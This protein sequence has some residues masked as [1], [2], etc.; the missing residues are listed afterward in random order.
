M[1]YCTQCAALV[2]WR[3]PAGDN[4][5]RHVCPDCGTVHYS[6]PRI[7][8]GCIPV[9]GDQILLCKRAIEPRAGFWT[10]PAGFMENQETAAQA[11]VRETLEEANARVEIEEPAALISV[12]H[13]SQVYMLFR[14]RLLD[15][16]FGP[17]TESLDVQLFAEHEIPWNEVAFSSIRRSLEIFFADRA[18]GRFTFR[19]EEI[20]PIIGGSESTQ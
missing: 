1:K 8:V 5:P 4:M 19:Y 3:I 11:A 10:L 13:I 18:N 16:G 6:N 17:G 7:I 20:Q 14:A 2:E 9:W 15:L 12:P